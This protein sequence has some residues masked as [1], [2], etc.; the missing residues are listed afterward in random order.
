MAVSGMDVVDTAVKIGLGAL[1]TSLGA[2]GLARR[3][4]SGELER[5]RLRGRKQLLEEVAL[6]VETVTHVALKYW[7]LIMEFTRNRELGMDLATHRRE[8]LDR[9]KLELFA[10]FKE[11]S[12]AEGKLLLLAEKEPERK[13]REYGEFIGAFRR[14]FY[15]EN[16]QMTEPELEAQRLELL[17]KRSVFYDALSKAYSE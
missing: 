5:E 14:K 3:T 4:H 16:A 10:S 7:A 8:E 6:Q 17:T 15:E 2:Y 1:I 13:L 12:G 9:T 11:F